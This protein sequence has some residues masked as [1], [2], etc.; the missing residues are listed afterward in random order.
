MEAVGGML[1][2]MSLFF[3]SSFFTVEAEDGYYE[4][5][6]KINETS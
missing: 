1:R 6:Q 5:D 2:M 3:F 4:G